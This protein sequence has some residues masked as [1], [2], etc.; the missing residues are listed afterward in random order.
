MNEERVKQQ[1]AIIKMQ[2]EYEEALE[3][4]KD[5]FKTET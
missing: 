4:L 1:E 3:T 5:K 2:K